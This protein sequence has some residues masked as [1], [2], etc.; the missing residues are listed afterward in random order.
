MTGQKP[1]PVVGLSARTVAAPE[2]GGERA[3]NLV[4]KAPG[5][6]QG[7]LSVPSGQVLRL[8]IAD[9]DGPLASAELRGSPE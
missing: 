3:I 6:Y 1:T 5:I 2:Q 8:S 7:E 4:A 9:R